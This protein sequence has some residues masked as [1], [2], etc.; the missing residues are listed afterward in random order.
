MVINQQRWRETPKTVVTPRDVVNKGNWY[1]VMLADAPKQ[2][3]SKGIIVPLRRRIPEQ[4]IQAK[5]NRGK[6]LRTLDLT[7]HGSMGRKGSGESVK[8]GISGISG[9]CL[10]WPSFGG[11]RGARASNLPTLPS[12][13]L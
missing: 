2:W 1:R 12:T 3:R 13:L 6:K 11:V 4:E 5:D 8:G 10:N 7:S 9:S